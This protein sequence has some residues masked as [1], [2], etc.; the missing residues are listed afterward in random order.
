MPDAERLLSTYD[1][2]GQVP[3]CS[4]SGERRVVVESFPA[5]ISSPAAEP[6]GTRWSDPAITLRVCAHII[7]AAGTAAADIFARIMQEAARMVAVPTQPPSSPT[8]LGR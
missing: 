6:Y 5:P 8:Y 7:R 3:T 4:H 2:I 1:S